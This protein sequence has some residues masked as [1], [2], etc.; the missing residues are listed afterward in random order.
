MGEK[1]EE[2][3]PYGLRRWPGGGG[4]GGGQR[5]TPVWVT[6]WGI[7]GSTGVGVGFASR[8]GIWAATIGLLIC[9]RGCCIW[10]ICKQAYIHEHTENVHIVTS[11]S[12]QHYLATSLHVL[13]HL[14][15]KETDLRLENA[16]EHSP[17]M[18]VPSHHGAA[19]K[20]R[21]RATL[22]NVSKNFAA[23]IIIIAKF[24]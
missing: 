20:L 2:E 9:W 22:E 19:L 6:A 15:E 7:R 11:H 14:S 8:P 12:R 21:E 10:G 5:G 18:P 4:G 1:G 16:S 24:R 3:C 23:K 13:L 17:P